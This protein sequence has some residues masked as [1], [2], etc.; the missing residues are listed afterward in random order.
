MNN[1]KT[2]AEFPL[3]LCELSNEERAAWIDRLDGLIIH[4]GNP[5]RWGRNSKLGLLI[6]CVVQTRCELRRL[7][8]AAMEER[9]KHIEVAVGYWKWLKKNGC[10]ASLETFV[11]GFN[12]Q[13]SDVIPVYNNV[14]LPLINT[15]EQLMKRG[16]K[17]NSE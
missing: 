11:N 12:Y 10:G 16:A 5:D 13:A 8:D 6:E 4:G 14:A 7:D 9:A 15:F 2:F 17:G 3:V 1:P